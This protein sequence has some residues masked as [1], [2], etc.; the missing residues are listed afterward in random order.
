MIRMDEK[1]RMEM[2]KF[3]ADQRITPGPHIAVIVQ[4]YEEASDTA[5]IGGIA[6]I[7]WDFAPDDPAGQ[8]G[9]FRRQYD[10]DTRADKSWPMAAHYRTGTNRGFGWIC[11]GIEDSNPGWEYDNNTGLPCMVGKKFG[12]VMGE[13]QSPKNGRFYVNL[14]KIMG[15]DELKGEGIPEPKAAPGYQSAP[16]FDPTSAQQAMAGDALMGGI[17]PQAP[18]APQTRAPQY[19]QQPPQAQ[20]QP[21]AP[22]YMRQAPIPVQP[23]APQAQYQY[24]QQQP[25]QQQYVQP[26][27][28]VQQQQY[29]DY[30]GYPDDPQAWMPIPEMADDEGL[31]FN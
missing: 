28:P 14:R 26:Q 9:Y 13:V 1:C 24:Q 23:Q 20:A 7:L 27:A 3:A 30:L 12:V 11:H 21:Q 22:Q 6:H 10:A 19:M 8:A 5:E 17:A 2:R 4:V 29:Q 16:A 15:I 18:Q 31:P 25:V